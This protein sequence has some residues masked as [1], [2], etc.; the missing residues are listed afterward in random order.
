MAAFEHFLRGADGA[1]RAVGLLE[2]D[3]EAEHQAVAGHVEDGAVV[4]EGDLGQQR[5]IFIQERDDFVRLEALGD[6]REAT[7]VGEEHD[8]VRADI[9]GREEGVAQLRVLQDFVCETG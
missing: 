4:T 1:L 5:E 7:Q 3:A 9:G 8:R 2:G 6:A